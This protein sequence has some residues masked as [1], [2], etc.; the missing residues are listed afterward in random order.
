MDESA[1]ENGLTC[2]NYQPLII[3]NPK[4]V[5]LIFAVQRLGLLGFILQT[6]YLIIGSHN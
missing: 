6:K 1:K 2:D 5:D 3:Q 4:Y